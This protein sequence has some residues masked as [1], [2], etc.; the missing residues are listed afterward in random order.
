MKRL[1]IF[2]ANTGRRPYNRM[3]V[4]PLGIMYLAAY[5]RTRLD[6]DFRLFDQKL[7]ESSCENV[8]EEAAAF[9]ADIVGLTVLTPSA[10]DAE[11][12]TREIRRRLPNA[13][14]ILGGPH[15]SALGRVA[16]K[17]AAADVAVPGEGELTLEAIIGAHCAGSGLQDVPGIFWRNSEGE[18]VANPGQVPV[19]RDLDA[20]PFPAYDLIDLPAYWQCQS[21]VLVP[22][23]RKCITLF[24]SRGCPYRCAYCHDVFG[25]QFRRHSAE[26]IVEEIE[27]Y[28]RE[29]G[30]EEV[31]FLD[32]VFNFDQ[33]RLFEFCDLANRRNLGVKVTFPNGL[34]ADLLSEDSID[35]LVNTGLYF[36][37]LALETA[38]PRIQKLMNRNLDI[39]SYLRAVELAVARRVFVSG[40]NL[41]GFPTETEEEMRLTIDTAC[42]SPLQ[43]AYFTTVVP[44]PG[45]ELHNMV[46]KTHG[47]ELARFDFNDISHRAD[48]FNFSDIPDERYFAIKNDAWRKFYLNPRRI[49]R[50][51]SDHP[52]PHY[53]AAYLPEVALRAAKGFLPPIR[54]GKRA[55]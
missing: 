49:L 53:L 10:R 19:L 32:D 17:Q 22:R 41:L 9:D 5:L 48:E 36:T 1:R 51:L 14:I 29:Y 39:P 12:T 15:V 24:S 34:R 26:R 35:A 40:F 43:V 11:Q 52:A 8:A 25:R 45:T 42:H 27:Y 13:R 6:A 18:V 20:L 33:K 47:E 38:S 55:C 16:L 4:P 37:A 7:H 3:V 46:A 31:D 44:W 54:V 23:R 30:V 21:G 50:I 28:K 2:L